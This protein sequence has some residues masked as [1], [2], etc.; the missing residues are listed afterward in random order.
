VTN[1]REYFSGP[2]GDV[3]AGTYRWRAAQAMPQLLTDPALALRWHLEIF[4]ASVL[5]Y[6]SWLGNLTSAST[7]GGGAKL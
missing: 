6:Q 1:A 7:H 3:L 2:G 4:R 5:L